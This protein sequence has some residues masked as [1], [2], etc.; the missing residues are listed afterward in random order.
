MALIKWA[1]LQTGFGAWQGPL[2]SDKAP[3]AS[4]SLELLQAPLEMLQAPLELVQYGIVGAILF[5]I[6]TFGAMPHYVV[7][8]TMESKG[9]KVKAK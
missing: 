4:E 1:N 3:G 7:A 2:E 5:G 9:I 6:F 8:S